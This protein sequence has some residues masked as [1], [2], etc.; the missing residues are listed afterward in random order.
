MCVPVHV[1]ICVHIREQYVVLGER[2]VFFFHPEGPHAGEG[3]GGA[4]G[5]HSMGRAVSAELSAL[6]TALGAGGHR[7]QHSSR[8]LSV[9][10]TAAGPGGGGSS[11]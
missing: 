2:G 10:M 9:Y 5:R 11:A 3:R 7:V 6:V 8:S 1:C 4:L